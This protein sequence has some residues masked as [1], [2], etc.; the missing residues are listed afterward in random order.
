MQS[1]S[2]EVEAAMALRLENPMPI[3]A[4]S[5]RR[6]GAGAATA[7]GSRPRGDR[8]AAPRTHRPRRRAAVPQEGLRQRLD[9]RHH[10]RGRRLEGDDLCLVR[11]QGGP[12]RSRGPAGMPRTS[13]WQSMSN[14]DGSLEA[15]LTEI[16]Q[17]FLAMVL[18]PPIL[19]FHRLMVSIGRTF[20]ETGRLFFRDRTGLRLQARRRLDREAAERTDTLRK[21]IRIG[22]PSCFSTC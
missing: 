8:R 18:S 3:Q 7:R 4:L 17:S 19:E 21:T 9:R 15:Q 5:G 20:P 1:K 16:G 12:V 2:F 11:R 22:S 13:F 10:R 14:T 6:A